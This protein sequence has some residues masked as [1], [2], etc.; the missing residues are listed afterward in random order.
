M[1]PD[2]VTLGPPPVP[3]AQKKWIVGCAGCGLLIVA[4][5][6]VLVFSIFLFVTG[7]IKSSDVYKTALQAAM[8]SS[9]VQSAL[10]EPIKDGWLPMGSIKTT[11]GYGTASIR[12]SISGPNG[13]GVIDVNANKEPNQPWRYAVLECSVQENGRII[14]LKNQGV[15]KP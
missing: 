1:L 3:N 12:I 14:N 7:I 11:N 10:G 5:F 8:D 6:L 15:S 13:K 2:S 4:G 9:E